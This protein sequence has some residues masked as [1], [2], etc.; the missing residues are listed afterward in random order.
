MP[1]PPKFRRVEFLPEVTVFKPAGVPT[2][3]LEEI[4]LSVEE[5]EAIRLKDLEGLEQED[6]AERMQVS[7][8][9]FQ[10]VLSLAREKVAT[11]LVEG[12]ALRVEGGNYRL[13]VRH[14]KCRACGHEFQVP[15]GTGERG[16]DMT[17]PKCDA[18]DVHRIDQG[19][20]GFGNMP[21]GRH[22]RHGGR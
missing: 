20:R 22:G 18:Q 1:R 19:G 8:P 21:W 14:F 12:K 7:R 4:I 11:A 3:D 17:C 9:T 6:C 2:R 10:R 5:L 16:I 13:A 15:F